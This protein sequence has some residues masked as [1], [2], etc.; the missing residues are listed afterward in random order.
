MATHPKAE[1]L[2]NS[3]NQVTIH[4]LNDKH[5]YS[6]KDE[7]PMTP[8]GWG[9]QPL[10]IRVRSGQ[11]FHEPNRVVFFQTNDQSLG[12]EDKNNQYF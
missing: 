6:L 12:K 4:S 11:K 9:N 2:L 5:T 8:Q 10:P 3:D 1:I 7:M